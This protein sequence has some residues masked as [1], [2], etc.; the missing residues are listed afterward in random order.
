ML[1]ENE[2]AMTIV[3]AA[4]Q[5]HRTIGPGLLE[6]AYEAIMVHELRKRGLNVSVQLNKS[7]S[8]YGLAIKQFGAIGALRPPA[9]LNNAINVKTQAIQNSIRTENE[10]RQA[11]A[12]ARK[13]KA[14][15]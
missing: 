15:A 14:I 5:V 2:I 8:Q 6:S 11:E 4:Y 13:R 1:R 10:V 12:E 9:A 3:D 7:L